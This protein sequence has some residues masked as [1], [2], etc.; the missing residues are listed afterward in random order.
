MQ[1]VG[2]KRFLLASPSTWRQLSLYPATHPAARQSRIKTSTLSQ[3]LADAVPNTTSG[4]LHPISLDLGSV[5]NVSMFAVR[6]E[7]G[8]MLFIPPFWFH[9]VEVEHTTPSASVSLYDTANAHA[10][11]LASQFVRAAMVGMNQDGGS[12][13][14]RAAAKFVAGLITGCLAAANIGESESTGSARAAAFVRDVLQ[15]RYMDAERLEKDTMLPGFPEAFQLE[16]C[17][18]CS[19]RDVGFEQSDGL[20]QAVDT[21]VQL[22]QVDSGI[23]EVV[24]ADAVD[25]MAAQAVGVRRAYSFLGDCLPRILGAE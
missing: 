24:L 22:M 23:G 5:G 18:G 13:D 10:K 2:T 17:F 4:Q 19:E 15:S 8:D 12:N 14:P 16:Q 1:L 20:Q 7:P 9:H 3:V 25:M 11:Q 6:L 21:C